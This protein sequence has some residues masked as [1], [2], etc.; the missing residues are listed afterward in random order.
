MS[1]LIKKHIEYF[2]PG[3]EVNFLFEGKT[4]TGR[5]LKRDYTKYQI[6]TWN[7]DIYEADHDVDK[8]KRYYAPQG[9]GRD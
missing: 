4:L 5:I 9:Y 8:V 6:Q 7:K 3:T 1:K 2:E